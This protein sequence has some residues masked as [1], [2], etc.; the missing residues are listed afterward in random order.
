MLS[1]AQS[2]ALWFPQGL[3]LGPVLYSLFNK[4]IEKINENHSIRVHTYADDA[5]LNTADV[6]NSGFFNLAKSLE[7]NKEWAKIN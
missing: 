6:K 5:S 7:E 2:F 3:T 4:K 1:D